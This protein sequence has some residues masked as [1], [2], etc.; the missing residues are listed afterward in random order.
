MQALL[1]GERGLV[2]QPARKERFV[3][4][5]QL[6]RET[7]ARGELLSH[8]IGEFDELLDRI[9]AEREVGRRGQP[10]AVAEV[11]VIAQ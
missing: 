3:G 6:A 2:M 1:D 11:D 10:V 8:L 4:K 9:G 5:N 7:Y